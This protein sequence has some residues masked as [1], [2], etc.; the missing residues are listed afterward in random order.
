MTLP[1]LQP[2]TDLIVAALGGRLAP[3]VVDYLDLFRDDGILQTPYVAAGSQMEWRGKAAI[4]KFLSSMVG[5]MEQ[6]S[7]NLTANLTTDR[8][9]VLE[10]S[11]QIHR[12]DLSRSFHQDYVAILELGDGRL[13]VFREYSNPLRITEGTR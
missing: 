9:A 3:G 5:S 1:F 12:P 7:M 2:V 13:T 4:E 6:L 8:G 10:Y 11:G